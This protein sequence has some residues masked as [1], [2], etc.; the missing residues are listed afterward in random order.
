MDLSAQTAT[1]DVI[2][3]GSSV[4]VGFDDWEAVASNLVW[5]QP[6]TATTTAIGLAINNA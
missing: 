3:S 6:W 5:F 2:M 1:A 4:A